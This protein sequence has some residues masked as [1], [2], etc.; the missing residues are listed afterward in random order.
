[1]LGL[2]SSQDPLQSEQTSAAQ[3]SIN[4]AHSCIFTLIKF[5]ILR[6]EEKTRSAQC[7]MGGPSVAQ[8][9]SSIAGWFRGTQ[10]GPNWEEV[11]LF[12]RKKPKRKLFFSDCV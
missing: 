7:T 8:A 9:L 3:V 4:T 10:T 5:L 1:M 12:N 11:D 6:L 2:G